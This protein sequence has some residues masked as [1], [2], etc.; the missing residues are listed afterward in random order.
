[1]ANGNEIKVIHADSPDQI[2]YTEYGINDAIIID[3]TGIWRD[4]Q[5]LGLHL[6]SKGVKSV[7][8][9]APGKGDL[10]ISCLALTMRS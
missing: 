5:G 8:L 7:L 6:K 4:E 9:T 10:K 2:D 1:M 3:N